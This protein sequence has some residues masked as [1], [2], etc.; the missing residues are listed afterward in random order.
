M[1]RMSVAAPLDSDPDAPLRDRLADTM[2]EEA[3]FDGWGRIALSAAGRQLGLP[4]GEAERL[5]PGGPL[6]ILGHLSERSDRR[7]VEEMENADVAALK[8]RDRI[9]LAVRTRL[10]RHA[11]DREAVRRAIALLSLPFNALLAARLLYRTVDAL[12]YAAGDTSTDFSFYTKR[13]TLA[14]VYSSTLLYWLNDRTPGSEATWAFL[15]RRIDD[16]MR[17]ERVKSQVRSWTD[18]RRGMAPRR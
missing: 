1:W 16:V 13:A 3:A 17:L 2:A 15:D 7:T 9:K 4:P 14:G 11:G 5:F 6:Q 18:L 12:W 10:E 8:I